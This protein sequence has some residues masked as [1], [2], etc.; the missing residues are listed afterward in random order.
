[1]LM[2][3]PVIP[4]TLVNEYER[5]VAGRHLTV[6]LSPDRRPR[7]LAHPLCVITG[8]R[9][10]RIALQV[11]GRHLRGTTALVPPAATER[12]R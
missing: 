4:G 3:D 11:A 9:G 6:L 12:P 5:L 10:V 1:M 7:D 2:P 8:S